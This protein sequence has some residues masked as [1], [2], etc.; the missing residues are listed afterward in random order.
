MGRDKGVIMNT[1]FSTTGRALLRGGAGTF[2]LAAALAATPALAQAQTQAPQADGQ[3]AAA[4]DTGADEVVVTG[5]LFKGNDTISPVTTLTTQDLD[6]RG[7]NTVQDALQQLSSNNGPSLTNSFTANG[8]FAGGAS[9]ISLRGLST[10]ST[11]V[12]FD[13]LRAA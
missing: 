2:A 9:S 6:T 7:I 8:A 4:Q 1:L 11:L 3:A 12:L 10:N 5:T 13:G